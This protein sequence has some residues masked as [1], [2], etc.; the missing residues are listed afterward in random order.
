M[1][2]IKREKEFILLVNLNNN[3]NFKNIIIKAKEKNKENINI[4]LYIN[5]KIIFK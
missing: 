4:I 2:L 1:E 5:N 3:I